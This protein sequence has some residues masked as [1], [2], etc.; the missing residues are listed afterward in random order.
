[1]DDNIHYA[2]VLDDENGKDH[3]V[4]HAGLLGRLPGGS[5]LFDNRPTIDSNELPILDKV[6]VRGAGAKSYVC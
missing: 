1:L 2:S 4:A 5:W 6:I 3:P